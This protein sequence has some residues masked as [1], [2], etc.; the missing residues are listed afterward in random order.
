[1]RIRNI[2]LV[3]CRYFKSLLIL[4]SWKLLTASHQDETLEHIHTTACSH[5]PWIAGL[6]HMNIPTNTH[7]HTHESNKWDSFLG[8]ETCFLDMNGKSLLQILMSHI[9]QIFFLYLCQRF[10][11]VGLINKAE[12]Q[13]NT[14]SYIPWNFN[15]QHINRY[16]KQQ[17]EET[18]RYIYY[19]QHLSSYYKTMWPHLYETS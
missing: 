19:I 2:V 17:L 16:C 13:N 5:I 9:F 14:K 3:L 8:Q 18:T 11:T 4:L 7:T 10:F 15:I 1:M 12:S 6:S